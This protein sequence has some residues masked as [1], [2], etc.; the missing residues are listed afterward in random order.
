[1][2]KLLLSTDYILQFYHN[3]QVEEYAQL[4]PLKLQ[5]QQQSSVIPRQQSI[6]THD[7]ATKQPNTFLL[8]FVML[9]YVYNP[10]LNIH[11]KILSIFLSIHITKTMEN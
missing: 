4:S 1:M 7:Q 5:K 6:Q 8:C 10:S 3:T 2:F 9:L 11:R